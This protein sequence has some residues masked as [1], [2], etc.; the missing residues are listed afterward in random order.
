MYGE[1]VAREAGDDE[2]KV[3]LG[4]SAATSPLEAKSLGIAPA[5][6]K[7]EERAEIEAGRRST[8]GVGVGLWCTKELAERGKGKR[9]RKRRAKVNQEPTLACAVRE[10]QKGSP[11]QAPD[12]Q[13]C[14]TSSP[15]QISCLSATKRCS[16]S[17]SRPRPNTRRRA[18][19]TALPCSRHPAPT[20]PPQHLAPT[21]APSVSA[22]DSPTAPRPRS[23][24][25][26]L[27]TPTTSASR[28]RRS[29]PNSFVHVPPPRPGPG[30]DACRAGNGKADCD[31][32]P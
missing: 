3:E 18:S 20:A 13:L 9:K 30:L 11:K 22:W 21:P 4:S 2:K 27:Q 1:R 17:R 15:N 10:L 5:P 32:I 19:R 7:S 26:P 16:H 25:S 28:P 29:S 23:T 24:P 14:W 6:V 8:E 12:R 31:V